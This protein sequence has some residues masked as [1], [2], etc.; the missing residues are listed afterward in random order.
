MQTSQIAATPSEPEV[1]K[2]KVAKQEVPKQDV[3]KQQVP[4]REVPMQ[5]RI[6]AKKCPSA[7]FF[8]VRILPHSDGVSLRIQSECRKIWTRKNSVFG[9]TH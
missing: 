6:T 4:K 5:V 1:S 7:E 2:Q 9:L 8:L 3:F